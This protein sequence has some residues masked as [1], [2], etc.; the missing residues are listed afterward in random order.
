MEE[1]E[2]DQI[3]DLRSKLQSEM[4][5][6]DDLLKELSTSNLSNSELEESYTKL[7]IDLNQKKLEI[8]VFEREISDL[9]NT[10][11]ERTEENKML[12]EKI[13]EMEDIVSFFL[14]FFLLFVYFYE[15]YLNFFFDYLI[16]YKICLWQSS[17]EDFWNYIFFNSVFF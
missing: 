17:L 11:L 2:S 10:L 5:R 8:E 16:S 3:S 4:K 1:E 14:F 15:G 9:R 7:K 6:K 12:Q 13:K